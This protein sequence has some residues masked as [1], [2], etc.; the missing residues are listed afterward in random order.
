M[1]KVT[2]Y[3]DVRVRDLAAH[4][5]GVKVAVRA[6]AEEIAVRAKADLESHRDLTNGTNHEIEVETGKLDSLV[7]MKGPA[8]W[9]LE[10]GHILSGWAAKDDQQGWVE[11]LFILHKAA[12]LI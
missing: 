11:G 5:P 7:V 2:I 10:F 9:A 1:A 3:P 4:R 6:Q 8:P 12:G